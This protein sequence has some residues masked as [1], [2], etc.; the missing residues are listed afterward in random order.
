MNGSPR[1][2]ENEISWCSFYVF[3]KI[4]GLL[5]LMTG[6]TCMV[7]LSSDSTHSHNIK[8]GLISKIIFNCVPM[9]K[10]M[11]Y[12]VNSLVKKFK[13]STYCTVEEKCWFKKHLFRVGSKL[14]TTS[15]INPNLDTVSDTMTTLSTTT[16]PVIFA[17]NL[18][19]ISS[20][21]KVCHT[22]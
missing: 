12:F 6:L 14:K 13:K 2:T 16:T 19:T 22:S 9:A 4:F 5:C 20:S 7:L 8:G 10:K 3:S 11:W 17:N 15:E 21:S 18:T 1:N